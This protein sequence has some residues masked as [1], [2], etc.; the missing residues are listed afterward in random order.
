MIIHWQNKLKHPFQ[1]KRFQK[2]LLPFYFWSRKLFSVV[3][4]MLQWLHWN[5]NWAGAVKGRLPKEAPRACL[6][7]LCGRSLCR[8]GCRCRRERWAVGPAGA[9]SGRPGAAASMAFGGLK[10]V[11]GWA[12]AGAFQPLLY[13]SSQ[14]ILTENKHGLR[15]KEGTVLNEISFDYSS[16]IGLPGWQAVL[17]SALLGKQRLFLLSLVSKSHGK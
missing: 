10:A 16:K 6:T 3:Y 17:G 11:A 14:R 13:L 4:A 1:V 15:W 2:H 9:R 8:G 5:D 7:Y 12:L